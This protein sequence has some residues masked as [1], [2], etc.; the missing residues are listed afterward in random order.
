MSPDSTIRPNRFSSAAGSFDSSNRPRGLFGR[1]RAVINTPAPDLHA[2][3]RFSGRAFE[4][5]AR[6][7]TLARGRNARHAGG[8]CADETRVPVRRRCGGYESVGKCVGILAELMLA[9]Q[10]ARKYLERDYANRPDSLSVGCRMC[11][12]RAESVEQS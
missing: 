3:D 2:Q 9:L 12:F 6:G 11:G 1:T 5:N 8:Y 10:V 4:Y 7:L